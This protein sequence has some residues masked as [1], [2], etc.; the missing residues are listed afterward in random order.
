MKVAVYVR[1]E[2]ARALEAEG[3]DPAQW[4]RD[5]VKYALEKRKG[6]A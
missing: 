5:L 6:K 2:D 1:Q 3:K 4:V